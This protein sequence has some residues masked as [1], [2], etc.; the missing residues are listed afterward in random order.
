MRRFEAAE[1]R[2]RIESALGRLPRSIRDT[3]CNASTRPTHPPL[4]VTLIRPQACMPHITTMVTIRISGSATWVGGVNHCRAYCVEKAE[5]SGPSFRRIALI[6][7][8][9]SVFAV[10]LFLG[11]A[12]CAYLGHM[13]LRFE[14][15]ERT[16]PAQ[17]NDPVF[18]EAIANRWV[19][20]RRS[21]TP[22][23]RSRCTKPAA[24]QPQQITAS[25]STSTPIATEPHSPQ[26]TQINT[27]STIWRNPRETSA[28][29]ST[30]S[31]WY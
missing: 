12:G 10:A 21:L 1:V 13:L 15:A 28:S 27:Q 18:N 26:R 6:S 4:Q 30:P 22:T 2:A 7:K 5:P 23:A 17:L 31:P 16:D 24:Q 19:P 11:L 14:T 25:G 8:S 20:S 29:P 9:W 3:V